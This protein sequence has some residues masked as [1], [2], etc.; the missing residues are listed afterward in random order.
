MPTAEPTRWP[1]CSTPAALPPSAG[2]TSDSVSVW[3]GA[4]TSPLPVPATSSGPAIAHATPPP[5]CRWTASHTAPTPASTSRRPATTRARPARATIRPP[6]A[7]PSPE[8]T[9]NGVIAKPAP[10]AL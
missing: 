7:E 2:G 6:A 4:M 3:L 1:V 5:G 8:P 9:A 10:S